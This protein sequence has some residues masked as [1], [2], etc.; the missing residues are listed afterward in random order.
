MANRHI[1]RFC[2]QWNCVLQPTHWHNVWCIY[3]GRVWLMAIVND[4]FAEPHYGE[5]VNWLASHGWMRSLNIRAIGHIY[6]YI[7][8]IHNLINTNVYVHAVWLTNYSS[9]RMH[10]RMYAWF[11]C[12]EW[13]ICL[14][15]AYI[16]CTMRCAVAVAPYPRPIAQNKQTCV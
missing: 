14:R 3:I 12:L 1:N 15:F 16:I 2:G 6:S 8:C 11:I 5:W 4:N 7:S 13:M 10:N 9:L